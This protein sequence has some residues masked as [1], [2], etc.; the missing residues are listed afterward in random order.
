[1]YRKY[2]CFINSRASARTVH[3]GHALAT[4]EGTHCALARRAHSAHA[5]RRTAPQLAPPRALDT[6]ARRGVL[7]HSILRKRRTR[8]GVG[9]VRRA[10]GTLRSVHCAQLAPPRTGL[11]RNALAACGRCVP[12]LRSVRTPGCGTLR[13]VRV[14]RANPRGSAHESA[15]TLALCALALRHPLAQA[16]ATV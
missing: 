9:A 4:A 10:C 15:H 11:S 5:L 6:P 14:V 3:E 1:M 12:A 13:S 7:A 8:R 2:S 16:Q